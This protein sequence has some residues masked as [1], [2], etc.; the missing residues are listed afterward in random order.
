VCDHA[1]D[2]AGA[3]NQDLAHRLATSG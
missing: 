2:A 3:D 1:T